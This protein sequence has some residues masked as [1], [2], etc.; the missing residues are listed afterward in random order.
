MKDA[1]AIDR[2]QKA[3]AHLDVHAK[4]LRAKHVK[5]I[6]AIKNDEKELAEIDAV[7]KILEAE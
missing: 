6:S 4:E 3:V 5:L 1:A 2:A 7:I